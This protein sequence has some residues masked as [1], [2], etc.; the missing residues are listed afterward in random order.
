MFEKKYSPVVLTKASMF[1]FHLMERAVHFVLQD[2]MVRFL[3]MTLDDT[4]WDEPNP[5]SG[6]IPRHKS[7]F[8]VSVLCRNGRTID[9]EAEVVLM[10][11]DDGEW[12]VTGGIEAYR[13]K[14]PNCK[15][16]KGSYI[17]FGTRPG[18]D[19]EIIRYC[20]WFVNVSSEEGTSP[21]DKSMCGVREKLLA[22]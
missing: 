19:G 15:A 22:T 7:E 4:K 18:T 11:R 1:A 17:Y 13:L 21:N 10:K 9:V 2:E 3:H 8:S 14:F 16:L 6:K 20:V 12:L 5:Y